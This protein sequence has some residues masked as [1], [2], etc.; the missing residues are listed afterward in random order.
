M[1]VIAT[2]CGDPGGANA[3][4]PVL[5]LLETEPGV[6]LKN[7]SYNQGTIALNLSG[8]SCAALPEKADKEVAIDYLV[9]AKANALLAATSC[10]STNWER[11]FFAAAKDLSLPSIAV[12]DSWSSYRERFADSTES[13]FHMPGRLAVMDDRARA[14]AVG[15]G[16]PESHIVITGQPAFDAL[17]NCRRLFDVAARSQQRVSL[18]VNGDELMILFVSQ[19]L[20]E[21]SSAHGLVGQGFDEFQVVREVLGS[22][23]GIAQD[24]GCKIAFVIRLHPRER[25]D[26]YDWLASQHVRILISVGGNSRDVAMSADLVVGMN[27]V[28]LLEACHLGCIVVSVQPGLIGDDSLPTNK[29]GASHAVYKADLIRKSLEECLLNSVTRKSMLS[30]GASLHSDDG[31]ARRVAT[32]TL[33]DLA[34]SDGGL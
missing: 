17:V 31:A 2:V 6:C 4:V 34:M 12:L 3:L 16:L 5:H 13:D 7:F 22:L 33:D 26:R 10:N 27:S 20:R 25:P 29:I 8:F 14:E 30:R 11:S 28:L 18:S 19:P 1:T 9:G 15:A 32:L 24:V 23:E 21:M